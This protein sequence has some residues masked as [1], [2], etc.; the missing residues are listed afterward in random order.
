MQRNTDSFPNV[1]PWRI[2]THCHVL[3]P[4]YKDAL[5]AAE[6]EDAG[7]RALPAWSPER[8]IA[9]MNA[10]NVR[11]GI[12]SVSTPGVA[13]FNGLTAV[14]L[15][16]QC[17]NY[18]AMVRAQYP[19]RFGF[20]ATVPSQYPEA[21]AH[22]AAR[23]LDVLHADGIIL[24]ANTRGKYVGEPGLEPLWEVLNVRHGVVFIHPGDLPGTPP[25][26]G[27][28]SYATDFP[29]D[30]TRAA[31]LIV[32]NGLKKKYPN[33]KFILS[34]A[35]GNVPYLS[36]RMALALNGENGL[37]ID[38]SLEQFSDFYFDLALSATEAALPSLLSFAKPGHVVFGSDWPFL[39]LSGA[40]TILSSYNKYPL[41]HEERADIDTNNALTLF[42]RYRVT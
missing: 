22:E 10:L 6:V 32:R 37:P 35:G 16:M 12:M 11:V 31:Y 39:P 42:P 38:D 26:P 7:G 40:T 34:H 9:A 4:F 30:T 8:A 21:A 24:I 5:E 25:P 41:S 3:P 18:C 2:D 1:R 36:Y 33:I 19:G 27:V 28:P 13:V 14:S 17:N 29:L 23:A 20:F 15:A